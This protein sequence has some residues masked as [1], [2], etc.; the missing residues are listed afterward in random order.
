MLV[1]YIFIL[2]II[3][4][5]ASLA[6][7]IIGVVRDSKTNQ[8]VPSA[9]IRIE[10]TEFFTTTGDSGFFSLRADVLPGKNELIL[11]VNRIGY[12]P[13]RVEVNLSGRDEPL[14]IRINSAVIPSQTILIKAFTANNIKSSPIFDGLDGKQIE[15]T[16]TTQDVP[17]M[18]SSLPS[19]T[20][21]SEG[22]SGIGYNYLS[23]RGFDQRRIA[24]MINGIPQNDP[25]DHN[26]YWVDMADLLG[27]TELIEIQRGAGGGLY[28]SP[29]IG[30]AINLVTRQSSLKPLSRISLSHGSFN[31]RKMEV[32][33]SS[34]II[35]GKYSFYSKFSKLNTTGYRD[36]SWADLNAYHFTLSRFDEDLMTQINIYGGPIADGLVYTGLPKFA[37]K[38]RELRRKNYSY[39]EQNG[40][41]FSYT[42]ERRPEEI[43]NFSQPHFEILNEWN[44]SPKL[45]FNSALFFISGNGFFNYDGS[46]GNYSYF[47]LVP[48]NGFPITGNPDTLYMSNVLIRANVENKQFGWLPRILWE[49]ENGELI[50]GIEL[51]KHTSFKWGII[52][53]A[54]GVPDGVPRNHRYH[55]F[56][57]GKDIAGL[58]VT[59]L[60]N[61]SD[62][63]QI[64]GELHF[65]YNSYRIKNEKYVGYDF[66]INHFFFNPRFSVSYKPWQ[67]QMIYFS[68]ARVSRE[69]RLRNY[70]DAAEASGGALPQFSLSADGTYN[71]NDPLVKPEKMNSFDLGYSFDNTGYMLNANIYLM[72]FQDEIVKQGQIDRLGVPTTGNAERTLHYGIELSGRIQIINGLSLITN[73]TY[74]K[75]YYKS[76][77][78]F[79][80]YNDGVSDTIIT[81]DLAGNE[82]AGFPELIWNSSIRYQKDDIFLQ[83]NTRYVSNFFSDNFDA[84]LS[85][86]LAQYPGIISYPDN[87]NDAYFTTD[88][89]ASVSFTL[90]KNNTPSRV[91]FRVSNLMDASYSMNA[92][93]GEFF[94][95]SVRNFQ[96]GIELGLF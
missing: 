52:D 37:L 24:V 79:M 75:N 70:Y 34:G 68:A 29:A 26:V 78:S 71:F 61:L 21:Y 3:L 49:H 67:E 85:S 43:E 44:I 91:F 88:F 33:A 93:G 87:V 60:Y 4:I 96:A 69:P 84:N 7:E 83:L 28:G 77:K 13:G 62:E 31:T 46:W 14:V 54:N 2:L 27:N 36:N 39:W 76:G 58:F 90:F 73:L 74:S 38:D 94:P 59:E 63:V 35:G 53:F 12:E 10:N 22:G 92:I 25:E 48:G 9:V 56:E 23:I 47:R 18:L 50:A 86:L 45:R 42:V 81:I 8:G 41:S 66:R 1:R 20:Y 40:E 19:A 15:K 16:H 30:G 80:P 17:E 5:P 55:Q 65:V 11:L 89:L 72:S 82:I 6:Q 32:E 57:S 64:S 51:R 95:A